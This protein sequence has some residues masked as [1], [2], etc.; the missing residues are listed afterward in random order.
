M[1]NKFHQEHGKFED[2][3]DSV[4][5]E[6]RD[7][8]N[9]AQ[10]LADVA[11]TEE[12]ARNHP[13][14]TASRKA[15]FQDHI[16]D[17]L[18]GNVLAYQLPEDIRKTV[19]VLLSEYDDPDII[20]EG[21]ALIPEGDKNV[22]TMTTEGLKEK[23][24]E[25]PVIED[26]PITDKELDNLLEGF[27]EEEKGYIQNEEQTDETLWQKTKELDIPEPEKN[28]IVLPELKSTTEDIPDLADSINVENIIPKEKFT[29]YK[30][31]L[32]TDDEYHQRVEQRINDM[33]TKLE[34]GEV[35]LNDLT[36]DDQKVIMEILNQDG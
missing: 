8:A 21:S 26:R 10:F 7:E 14:M 12:E 35:K 11:L 29:R 36:N 15:F 30:K 2:V 33:I 1:L 4:L 32:A 31:R 6:E 28:E 24:T 17:V 27:E 22:E 16:D 19:A 20:T 5:K 25:Q 18:R 9:K 34:N 13:P 23:F 3:D